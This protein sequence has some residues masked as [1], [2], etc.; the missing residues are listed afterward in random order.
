MR[1][2]QDRTSLLGDSLIHDIVTAVAD[3]RGIDP[4]EMDERLYE[5]VDP[6]A[7]GHLF[8]ERS[9]GTPRR[10]GQ[11]TFRLADCEVTVDGERRISVRVLEDAE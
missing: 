3:A 7:L 4:I 9:D 10:G 2:E 5:V 6:D 11:L 1:L 8:A